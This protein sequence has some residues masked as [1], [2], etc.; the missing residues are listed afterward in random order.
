MELIIALI[1]FVAIV[2]SWLVLPAAPADK[3]A[4]HSA[5]AIPASS[6]RRTA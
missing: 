4:G 5:G 3:A 2:A 6:A 1:L